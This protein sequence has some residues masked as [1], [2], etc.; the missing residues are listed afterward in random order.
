MRCNA[1]KEAGIKMKAWEPG[2]KYPQLHSE[3]SSL[4]ASSLSQMLGFS[5]QGSNTNFR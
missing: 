5:L 1:A 3:P 4:P 2:H